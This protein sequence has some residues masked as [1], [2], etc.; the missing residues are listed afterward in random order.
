MP[1]APD[2]REVR[3]AFDRAAATYDS[4]A[5][6]Q[7]AACRRLFAAIEADDWKPRAVI[8]AG[9]GTGYALPLLR[10]RFPAAHL[11]A[12]DFA[13]GMLRRLADDAPTPLCADLETLPLA[14][15]SVD[16]VWTSL[17]LQWCALRT[18]LAE[19]ARVLRPGGRAWLATL[20]PGTLAELREAFAGIDA[21][22]HV[23]GFRE[24]EA[25]SGEA[26]A[27]GLLLR[28]QARETLVDCAPD[29]AA[30]LRGLKAL[31]AASV[32]PER[33]R[34]PL[35]RG[36][37]RTV[38]ERYERLRTARGLPASYDLILLTLHKP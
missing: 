3:A 22:A 17:A 32:G 31:G 23:I 6:V 14:D 1:E 16:A 10:E 30:L 29:L 5:A 18:A 38:V 8:D 27:A 20:G 33:R 12:L 2:K 24:P 35:G 25:V 19:F 9:C 36:A 28:E 11:I 34:V 37:W 4:V 7:R 15:A 21:A 26:R 13:P